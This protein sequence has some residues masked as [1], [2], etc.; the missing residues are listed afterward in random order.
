MRGSRE[1]LYDFIV[2]DSR[3]LAFGK[4]HGN[5]LFKVLVPILSARYHL[6]VDGRDNLP[7]DTPVSIV[8]D[9]LT[10]HDILTQIAAFGRPIS[11]LVDAGGGGKKWE[12][13]L[14]GLLE[15][16]FMIRG[17]DPIAKASQTR[18]TQEIERK[19]KAGMSTVAW[20]GGTYMPAL[21]GDDS[22][23]GIHAGSSTKPA[24][25]SGV[26][27]I[28]ATE[29]YRPNRRLTDVASAHIQYSKPF[30]PKQYPDPYAAADA[31]RQIMLE[32]KAQALAKYAP[33]LTQAEWSAVRRAEESKNHYYEREYWWN[34]LDWKLGDRA[35]KERIQSLFAM[36]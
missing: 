3:R 22:V 20:S 21:Y 2:N 32:Q 29:V 24:W 31:I 16:T 15:P 14:L 13:V 33:G 34:T 19:Q 10:R 12:Q 30:W 28:V 6:T 5:T 7:T 8:A 17:V 23:L 1:V 26:P 11:A 25:N 18:A 27:I 35:E 4:K 9:H 36:L